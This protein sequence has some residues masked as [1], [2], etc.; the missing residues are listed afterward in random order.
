VEIYNKR[1]FLVSFRYSV[2]LIL[3]FECIDCTPLPAQSRTLSGTIVDADSKERLVYS[4]VVIKGTNI[5]THTNLQ[6]H[7]LLQNVPDTVLVLQAT[8][9]GYL[10]GEVTVHPNQQTS[11][12]LIA[13]TQSAIKLGGVTV[14]AEQSNFIKTENIPGLTTV[15]PTQIASLPSVGQAD[16]FRSIGLLPGISATSD[17]SSDLYVQGGTPD[18]NLILFDGMTVYQV[19]HFFGFFSAFNP[20][21]I[22]DVQIYKG[23]FPANFGGRLSSVI[24]IVGRTGDPDDLHG[25]AGLSLLSGNLSL[26][27]PLLGGSFFLAGRRS[28]SDIITSGTYNSIYRFLTGSSSPTSTGTPR[29]SA[30]FGAIG[31]SQQQTPSSDFYDLNAKLS[32]H[33][34]SRFMLSVSYYGSGD[35][36]DLSQQG[37]TQNVPG[38]GQPVALPSNSNNTQQGNNGVS[39]NLFAQW[40]D[41]LYSNFIVAYDNY[42]S[43]YTSAQASAR[44]STTQFSTDENNRTDDFSITGQNDW[45][46]G[47]SQDISF[48]LELSQTSVRYSLTGSLPTGGTQNLLNLNQRAWENAAYL[49]DQLSPFDNFILTGGL[50]YENYTSRKSSY[51][52]P[53]V[54]ASYQL[55][56]NISLKGA[57]GVY[58]QFVNRIE[59]ENVTGGSRDFWVLAD[60]S[61][62]ASEA[63]HYIIGATWQNDDYVID[64]EGFYKRLDNIAEFSQRFLRNAYEPYT[65]LIGDGRIRGIQALFQKK[66]GVFNGWISYTFMKAEDRFPMLNDYQYFPASNDQT[67][68][69]KIIGTYDPGDDWNISATFIYATGKPYTAPISQYSLV[70]LDGTTNDYVHV[71]PEN[72]YRVP[73]YQR[74][75]LSVSKKFR[76]K[77]SSLN[78]G[79]SAFNLYNHTNISYYQYNLNTQPIVI[80]AVTGLGFLPSLF[81]QYEF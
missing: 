13:I 44:T 56:G 66:A 79:L 30:R 70:L 59:N 3:L 77:S 81:V 47:P 10:P 71:S 1:G 68:E 32:Q 36:Y 51:I 26:S 35:N 74:L 28:Y 63:T 62:P 76:F 75:D 39:A 58:H 7:F 17:A 64:V 4:N 48:G 40:E 50:R 54:S 8:Y 61:I 29:G 20:D 14:S 34:G 72:A 37:S 49:Q 25:R 6:G 15:S 41:N 11:G 65:F 27:G 80:T 21:A 33:L 67:H 43:T 69:L 45:K 31:I 60:T 5:G 16:I 38:F 2:T 73:D 22:K 12:I 53:R 24:D 52:E 55:T 19:D 18:E 9:V 46:L 23:G 57:F 42:T 78:L